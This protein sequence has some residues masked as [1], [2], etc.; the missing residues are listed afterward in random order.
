MFGRL[1]KHQHREIGGAQIV[2]RALERQ[3]LCVSNVQSFLG[4]DGIVVTKSGC[5][6][7]AGSSL[8]MQGM[9][10]GA[11]ISNCVRSYIRR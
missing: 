5:A 2:G 8:R 9:L 11:S 1:F 6:Q 3:Y 10:V 4:M 7:N